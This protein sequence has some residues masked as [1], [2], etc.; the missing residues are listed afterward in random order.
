LAAS[1]LFADL[2]ERPDPIALPTLLTIART[3]GHPFASA[4]H[5]NL[6]LLIGNDFANDWVQWESEVQRRLS[7]PR[8]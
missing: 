5:T 3:P 6:E 2:M 8:N 1:I 4:A 7:A